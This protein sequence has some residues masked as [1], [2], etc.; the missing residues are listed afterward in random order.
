MAKIRCSKR[1]EKI[2]SRVILKKREKYAL[3]N[4][5]ER[6]EAES[7]YRHKDRHVLSLSMKQTWTVRT[8]KIR[9]PMC[10]STIPCQERGLPHISLSHVICLRLTRQPRCQR[11][12]SCRPAICRLAAGYRPGKIWSAHGHL[13][14]YAQWG[15]CLRALHHISPWMM[16]ASMAQPTT[17]SCSSRRC[18]RQTAHASSSQD[19]SPSIIVA[20]AYLSTI[21]TSAPLATP[22]HV[23]SCTGTAVQHITAATRFWK[24]TALFGPRIAAAW[25]RKR[26]HKSYDTSID[27]LQQSDNSQWT[28][29]LWFVWVGGGGGKLLGENG[30]HTTQIGCLFNV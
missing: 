1:E 26:L 12:T 17:S 29:F 23:T 2:Y 18:V 28:T 19:S 7:T 8:W 27:K 22:R 14:S 13:R 10:A 6:Q 30:N 11:N 24:E 5:N 3:E 16:K 4:K 25:A 20:G 9:C 21:I 15:R